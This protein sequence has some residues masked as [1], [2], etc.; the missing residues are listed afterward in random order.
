MG[1]DRST[2]EDGYRSLYE[3][4]QKKMSW[5]QDWYPEWQDKSNR[6]LSVTLDDQLSPYQHQMKIRNVVCVSV[7]T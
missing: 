7:I 4:Q 1:R 3:C 6:R 2:V 5:S